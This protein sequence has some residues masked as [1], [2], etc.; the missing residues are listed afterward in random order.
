MIDT[1]KPKERANLHPVLMGTDEIAFEDELG[2]GH[3]HGWMSRTPARRRNAW[4]PMMASATRRRLERCAPRR[5]PRL[6]SRATPGQPPPGRQRRPVPT[7][8]AS[9]FPKALER[10]HESRFLL[11]IGVGVQPEQVPLVAPAGG[12]DAYHSRPKDGRTAL[13]PAAPAGRILPPSRVAHLFPGK[14]RISPRW[15]RAGGAAAVIRAE[16]RL[17]GGNQL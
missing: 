5:L 14:W 8:P 1:A 6:D 10:L 12:T 4:S 13:T 9:A 15:R 7:R 11:A 16:S 3:G 17:D 2:V